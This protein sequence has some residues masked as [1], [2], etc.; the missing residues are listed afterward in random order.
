[1]TQVKTLTIRRPDNM[2]VH[3]RG[4]GKMRS[5]VPHVARQYGRAI[6]MP[7]VPKITTVDEASELRD[8]IIAAVPAG[9]TLEPLM[10]LYLQTTT[11]PETIREAKKSGFVHG[12]K[13]YP[14]G[15]TTG[16]EGG[17]R[18]IQDIEEQLRVME[19]VDMPLLVHGESANP[20]DDVFDRESTFY[21]E[22][23]AWLI[24]KFPHLR[25]VCEHITTAT[26]VEMVR[27]AA[28]A[29]RIG[30]TITPQHLL[31]N[32]TDMLGG[33][34]KPHY[35]CKPILK[36]ENDRLAL[37]GAA[38]S[39]E[40]WFFLGDDS[41]PHGVGA[42]ECAQGC[43]GC[44]TS[45]ASLE[46]YAE[47]FDKAN[48]LSR[49]ENFASRFGAEFYELPQND[50]VITLKRETWQAEKQYSF[51]PDMVVPFRQSEPLLWRQID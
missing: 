24:T 18:R 5:V 1:M 2:H 28:N 47:A 32:R 8:Q 37:V 51:G 20:T 22:A 44:F 16:A 26:A 3:V 50:G 14:E 34:I 12:L 4:G 30:A 27:R 15:V 7:N 36:T 42:K 46:F 21:G 40:P 19:L 41:A 39:D 33:L 43:A 35:F 49:F 23:F 38:T 6:I 9:T 13:L 48:A 45:H 17:V 10:T 25:I 29:C 11:K 31:A